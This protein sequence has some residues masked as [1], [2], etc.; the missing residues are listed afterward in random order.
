MVQLTG[1]RSMKQLKKVNISPHF[2]LRTVSDTVNSFQINLLPHYSDFI[3]FI[4][5][6][7]ED[8]FIDFYECNNLGHTNNKG[9]TSYTT[10]EKFSFIPV[11]KVG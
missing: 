5:N 11:S 9:R 1:T 4:P 6:H 2:Y 3:F 7:S 10:V 8:F